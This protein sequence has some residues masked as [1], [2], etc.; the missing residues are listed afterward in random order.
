MLPISSHRD[1]GSSSTPDLNAHL[2]ALDGLRGLAILAVMIFHQTCLRP[3]TAIDREFLRWAG[4]LQTGVDLFFV[5]SGF[6]ITGILL[7]SKESRN[8][9]RNFYARRVLRIFPLY[10][11]ILI[12]GLVVLPRISHLKSEKWGQLGAF[13]Q[14]WYW[15]FLSNWWIAWRGYGPKNGLID[16]SWTLAIEE[17]FYLIWPIAVWAFGRGR[18]VL[19][20]VGLIAAAPLFRLALVLRG[21]PAIWAHMMTPARMDALAIGAII[22][23][24]ARGPAGTARL[25]APARVM[26]IAG[27]L[28]SVVLMLLTRRPTGPHGVV[29]VCEGTV[30]PTF[31][32]GLLILAITARAGGLAA[33]LFSSR[34][35]RIFGVSSYALYLC[36]NPIQAS[37]RD[38]I[39]GPDNFPRLLGS[40]IPGQ[41][42]FCVVATLAA[43]G[44]A[45]LSWLWFEEPI[46]RLKR[47]FPSG[48]PAIGR[49]MGVP[50]VEG[51]P[52]RCHPTTE[53]EV[54]LR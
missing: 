20:C 23:L 49:P 52:A 25:I 24:L 12:L 51:R 22:A 32:G 14:L 35:L 17:Q 11:L 15:T 26:A 37:I 53:A 18:L 29:V 8:Y 4:F 41:V 44:C 34:M 3:A 10:Y 19:I 46:L 38:K 48:R 42:L 13:E 21:S 9:F 33:R 54:G 39:Y 5:I 27:G 50:L 40:S 2:P 36:H 6:L 1:A 43:L 30:V 31:F 7:E 16:L 47:Y 45:R 28:A